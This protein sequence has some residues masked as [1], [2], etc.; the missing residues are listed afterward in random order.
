MKEPANGGYKGRMNVVLGSVYCS[1]RREIKPYEGYQVESRV[2]GWDEKW[3]Y[4]GS[5]F[6]RKG[7]GTREVLASALS[8]YVVKKG[9]FT[10]GPAKVLEASG[11]LSTKA[12]EKR[13][14]EGE[15]D[16]AEGNDG[17][18][19]TTVPEAASTVLVEITDRSEP[20][21]L[22]GSWDHE[23]IERQRL[24]G[25]DVVKAFVGLDLDVLEE[26]EREVLP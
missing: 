9:R 14:M 22:Q 24:K 16:E 17:V 23:A 26:F 3:M 15:L 19:A 1:F 10:V 21:E 2:L 6:V 8:K 25:M 11:Y 20:K 12:Q 4:I 7:K 13:D 5:W 18:T